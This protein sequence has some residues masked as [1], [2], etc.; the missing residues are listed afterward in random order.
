MRKHQWRES[1]KSFFGNHIDPVKDEQLKGNK[2]GEFLSER[3]LVNSN[4]HININ[5]KITV[6]FFPTFAPCE[7]RILH[8]HGLD[9]RSFGV[10][11]NRLFFFLC[12][13]TK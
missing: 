10:I 4:L 11:F 7:Y 6:F 1:I 3:A 2:T 13:K 5:V 12:S 9:L 8:M